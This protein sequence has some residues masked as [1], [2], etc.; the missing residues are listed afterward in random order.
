MR[1]IIA[2]IICLL[3]TFE[4]AA[5]V[6]QSGSGTIRLNGG[7]SGSPYSAF[8][9]GDLLSPGF[10]PVTAFSGTGIGLANPYFVNNVNPAALTSIERPVS[11]IFD[12]G[13]KLSAVRTTGEEY[14]PFQLDG[15]LTGLN[16]WFRFGN[17]W[18]SNVGIQPYSKVGYNLIA[19]RYD[20]VAGGDYRVIYTGKGGVNRLYWGNAFQLTRNL[21]IGANLNMLF[22]TIEDTQIFISESTLGSFTT[23]SKNYL[24]GTG[25]DAGLQYRIPMGK[26]S[27]MLGLT[28]AA[29]FGLSSEKESSLFA[30]QDTLEQVATLDAAYRIPQKLGAGISFKASE[31]LT[32]AADLSFQSWSEGDLGE[33]AALKDS[34][35]VSFGA[36]FIPTYDKYRGYYQQTLLRAGFRVQDG[37]LEV[38]G[39]QAREWQASVGV[40]LPFNRARHH[41]NLNY[42][43]TQRGTSALLESRHQLTLS[44]S[45]RDV[46]FVKPKYR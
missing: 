23:T 22:G 13:I 38:D 33:G 6:G 9:I 28:Y 5:Q 35:A 12:L 8:G 15:G 42:A 21:S 24:K 18:A 45:L 32:L 40:G 2:I 11:M 25:F 36:E 37:Y 19:E 27:L 46:W 34:R 1:K 14:S 4:L 20:P 16:L 39:T 7:S 44:I 10:G 30:L 3:S 17:Q 41:L 31:R 26:K 29:P 43:Y